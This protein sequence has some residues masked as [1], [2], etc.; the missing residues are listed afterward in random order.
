MKSAF[1]MLAQFDE[2]LAKSN[3]DLNKTFVDRFVKNV[4]K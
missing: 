1:N 2:E 4:K 3:V